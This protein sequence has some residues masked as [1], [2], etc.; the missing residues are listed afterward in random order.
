MSFELHPAVA[1]I[2]ILSFVVGIAIVHKRSIIMRAPGVELKTDVTEEEVRI[3]PLCGLE[4]RIVTKMDDD[5][6]LPKG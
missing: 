4:A 6:V 2:L 1:T 3:A 5:R